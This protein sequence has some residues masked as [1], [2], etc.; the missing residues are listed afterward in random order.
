MVNLYPFESTISKANCKY[1]DAIE[2]IDIGGP[3]MLRAAAKNHGRVTVITEPEDYEVVIKEINDNN[4]TCINTRRKL[5]IKVFQ[6]I[7]DSDSMIHHYLM[8]HDNTEA[9]TLPS[10][11]NIT[12]VKIN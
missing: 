5:A 2:N 1:D 8:S 4:Q 11:I 12:F 6:K 7:S 10:K 9:L 3:T